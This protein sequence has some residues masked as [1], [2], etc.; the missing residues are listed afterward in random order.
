MIIPEKGIIDPQKV[1]FY[2]SSTSM[3]P[4][5]FPFLQI[6]AQRCVSQIFKLNVCVFMKYHAV[7]YAYASDLCIC[8]FWFITELSSL[9]LS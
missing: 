8:V 1:L 5:L 2:F 7:L 6:S 4:I 9:H 3:N